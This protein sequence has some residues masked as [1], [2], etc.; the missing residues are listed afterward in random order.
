MPNHVKNKVKMEGITSIPEYNPDKYEDGGGIDFNKII[1][2]PESLKLESGTIE[3]LV[4]DAINRK[5]NKRMYGRLI[6]DG[7]MI[8]SDKEFEERLKTHKITE[9]QALELGLQYVT[10]LV[11]HG[12]TTWYDWCCDHWGTKWNAYCDNKLDNDVIMFETAWAA[13]IPVMEELS[14]SYPD[15]VI[16]HWWADEN[17]GYN[18]GHVK[19]RDGEIIERDN[20]EDG[21][22]E[23]GQLFIKL[24]DK[25]KCYYIDENGVLCHRD[26]DMCDGC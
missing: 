1:P 18:I 2:M 20:I 13:P 19:Y 21:T 3:Y 5:L 7:V 24:W 6:R 26:C 9:Q 8:L 16:E 14:K 4:I 23:A 11:R 17:A 10:N 12:A 22:T 25:E 15:K